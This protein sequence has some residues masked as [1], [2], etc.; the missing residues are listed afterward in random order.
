VSRMTESAAGWP[1]LAA[2]TPVARMIE[3][4][5]FMGEDL[6]GERREVESSDAGSGHIPG[7]SGAA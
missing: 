5:I 2:M 6:R 4:T 7:R 1:E 3:R